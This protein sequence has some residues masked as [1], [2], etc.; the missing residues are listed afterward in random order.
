MTRSN[1]IK[2]IAK[3]AE[4]RENDAARVLGSSQRQ[5]AEHQARL[6]Q[7]QD[8]QGEYSDLLKEQGA[9]GLAVSRFLE[10][11]NFLAVL[12][13][14]ICLQGK[15][16]ENSRRNVECKRNLWLASRT[17]LEVL[18]KVV[19]RFHSQE[20]YKQNKKEQKEC[21]DIAQAVSTTR[22]ASQW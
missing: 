8:F 19:E 18:N 11:Q 2:C 13:Q 6:L 16:L 12:N 10:Y 4:S 5:M 9:N 14:T 3:I 20:L 17:R 7:L 15:Q 1:R 21:D 22:R